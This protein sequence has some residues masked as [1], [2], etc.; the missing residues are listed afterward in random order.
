MKI[1]SILPALYVGSRVIFIGKNGKTTMHIWFVS[2]CI[3]CVYMCVCV[4]DNIPVKLQRS[5]WLRSHWLHRIYCVSHITHKTWPQYSRWEYQ[6]QSGKWIIV[7]I[8]ETAGDK[9]RV[10]FYS[11]LFL[12]ETERERREERAMSLMREG[13]SNGNTGM[14]GGVEQNVPFSLFLFAVRAGYYLL[15]RR[16]AVAVLKNNSDYKTFRSQHSKPIMSSSLSGG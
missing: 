9:R 5:L 8:A 2:V 11:W 3:C 14:E 6:A 10:H 4:C 13:G 12:T 15:N 7:T 16:H 1:K